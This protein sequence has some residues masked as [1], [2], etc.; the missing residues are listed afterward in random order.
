[1]TSQVRLYHG[2]CLDVL[3]TLEHVQAVVTDPSYGTG[4]W[5]RENAGAGGDPKATLQIEAWDRWNPSWLELVDAPT[6]G[7]FVP[8]R[9]GRHAV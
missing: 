1:M 8:R 2:D 5:K 4:A 7:L 6:V 3:P 9:N